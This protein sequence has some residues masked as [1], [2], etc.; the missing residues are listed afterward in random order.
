MKVAFNSGDEPSPK[1]NHRHIQDIDRPIRNSN[2][3]RMIESVEK[4]TQRPEP[5]PP[6]FWN[7]IKK[8]V[9]FIIFLIAF[10]YG[11]KISLL[12]IISMANSN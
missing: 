9:I 5:G 8:A 2:F 12:L 4:P 10:Y 3:D 1:R 11:L 6:S 7:L